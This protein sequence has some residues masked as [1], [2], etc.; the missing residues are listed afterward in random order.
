MF[1]CIKPTSKCNF[2]CSFCSAKNLKI[3]D[4]KHFPEQIKEVIRNIKPEQISFTGGEPLLMEPEYYYEVLDFYK[5][6]ISITSNLKAFYQNPDK[7]VPLFKEERFGVC[8]SFQFGDA[9]RWDIDTPY[10]LDKFKEVMY[11]FKDKVGYMP[12][13]IAVISKDNE[14]TAI[15]TILLAKEL[16]TTVRINGQ[17][18]L[19]VSKEYYPKYKLIDLWLKLEELGLDKYEGNL[20]TKKFGSCNFN[21]NLL[22]ASCNRACWVDSNNNLIYGICEDALTEGLTKLEPELEQPL[23]EHTIPNPDTLINTKCLTCELC[24]FCNACFLSQRQAKQDPN[25]CKEMLKRL[26][27][28]KESGW[29]L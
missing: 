5:G 10:T 2:N 20:E 7:W 6:N 4:T 16:G 14:D 9:R 22:C 11:L 26:P 19:G 17:M 23:P 15:E 13:F 12:A 18:L 24:N 25:Y 21:T 3:K 29:Y 28:I 1:L 27:R 8:T